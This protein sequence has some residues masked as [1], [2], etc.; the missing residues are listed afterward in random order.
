MSLKVER[1]T[2]FDDDF[3]T[4]KQR[5]WRWASDAD[6]SCT[7]CS[8]TKFIFSRT[9][10]LHDTVHINVNKLPTVVIVEVLAETPAKIRFTIEC[11]VAAGILIPD[12]TKKLNEQIDDIEKQ[13]KTEDVRYKA[14]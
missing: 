2:D 4:L 5:L 10:N 1:I 3:P 11:K 13:L 12:G 7:E 9:R 6:F 14:N 8:E